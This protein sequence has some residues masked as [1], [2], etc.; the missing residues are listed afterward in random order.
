MKER[1][2]LVEIKI[3]IKMGS[4]L[5]KK[6]VGNVVNNTCVFSFTV[7]GSC[8]QVFSKRLYVEDRKVIVTLQQDR[9]S[10]P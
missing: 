4:H 7:V 5:K 3:K 8:D 2:Q 10:E 6:T 1:N 9:N